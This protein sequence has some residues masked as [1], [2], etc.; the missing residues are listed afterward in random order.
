MAQ[1]L[2]GWGGGWGAARDP[3]KLSKHRSEHG[4]WG[5]RWGLSSKQV[6]PKI[7]GSQPEGC[8]CYSGLLCTVHWALGWLSWM[9]GGCQEIPQRLCYCIKAEP[10]VTGSAISPEELVFLLPLSCNCALWVF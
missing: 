3:R 10:F 1:Q 2:R 4:N 6:G 9:S 7:C 5:W 8:R